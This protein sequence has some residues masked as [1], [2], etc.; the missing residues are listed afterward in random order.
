MLRMENFVLVSLKLFL[1]FLLS[2]F[3]SSFIHSFNLEM[4]MKKQKQMTANYALIFLIP[5][6]Y[7]ITNLF[8]SFSI[9]ITKTTSTT[10]ELCLFFQTKCGENFTFGVKIL[11][12]KN[13]S[14]S[15][16]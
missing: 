11:K 14:E 8:V 10:L 12:V 7:L 4:E 16:S 1:Q 2:P 6:C 3:F 5:L 15:K 13:N 9:I